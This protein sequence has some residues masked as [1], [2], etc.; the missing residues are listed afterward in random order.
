MYIGIEIKSMDFVSVL[1]QGFNRVN[2]AGTTAYV[3]QYLHGS[4]R[5]IQVP[6][7]ADRL[8]INPF[9]RE[10]QAPAPWIVNFSGIDATEKPGCHKTVDIIMINIGD[11]TNG[12]PNKICGQT[13]TRGRPQMRIFCQDRG[14]RQK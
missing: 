2:G 6:A 13:L 11:P 7:D 3:S 1:P 9:A 4:P 5:S 12:L 8:S 10:W 14:G